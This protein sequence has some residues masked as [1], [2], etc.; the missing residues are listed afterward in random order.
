MYDLIRRYKCD[1]FQQDMI[2]ALE[3]LNDANYWET[4][5][6]EALIPRRWLVE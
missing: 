3:K 6:K 1:A 5:T 2:R 4:G